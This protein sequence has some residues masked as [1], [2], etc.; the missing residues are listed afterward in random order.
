MEIKEI[1]TALKLGKGRA[2]ALELEGICGA[3]AALS[4]AWARNVGF[5]LLRAEETYQRE[6]IHRWLERRAVLAQNAALSAQNAALS[7]Q[8]AALSAHT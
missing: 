6:D 3:I 4:A 1:M 2:L 7:A 5:S 8:N